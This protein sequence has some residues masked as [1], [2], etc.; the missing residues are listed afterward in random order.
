MAQGNLTS[1]ISRLD[2][3]LSKYADYRKELNRAPHTFVFHKRTLLSETL[4]Q[5][6]MGQGMT[7]NAA[8]KEHIKKLVDIAATELHSQLEQIAGTKLKRPG[9]KTTVIFDAHTDVP[10]P[11][12]LNQVLPYPAFTRVKFAYRQVMNKFFTDM[13][14]YFRNHKDLDT[15]KTKSGKEK[16]SIMHFFD[17]GHDKNAGVFERFLDTKTASIMAAI[18]NKGESA[19]E[20]ERNKIVAEMNK[21]LGIDLQITKLDDLDSIIIKI[22]SASSNRSRGQKQGLRSRQLRK[23]V[24]A[25][26]KTADL[27][28]LQGSDSLKTRKIKKTKKA[29]IDPFTKVSGVTVSAK[30]TKAKKSSK[31]PV[32]KSIKPSITKKATKLAGTAAKVRKSK[33]RRKPTQQGPSMLQIIAMLN[34]ELPQT[35]RKNMKSPALVNRTGRFAESVR[36]T[37]A[38]KTPQGFP[39]IGYTYQRDPYQVFEDGSSGNWANGNRD[40]RQLIDGSIREIAAQMAIGRFYTRRV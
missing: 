1:F 31:K 35:V 8:D 14:D 24:K 16:G 22:E 21:A 15:I 25:Y 19:S 12:H 9:G 20:E 38:V 28:N 33:N 4:T 30:N 18:N 26:L 29:V 11:T 5:L 23:K 7:L 6:S 2:K 10:I 3:E 37:D 32:S 39:S 40:P 13:Q 27:E 34:K 17:A 36:I